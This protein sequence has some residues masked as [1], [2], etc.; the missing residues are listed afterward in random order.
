MFWEKAEQ[1]SALADEQFSQNERTPWFDVSDYQTVVGY[2]CG[3]VL[4]H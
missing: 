3:R 1:H 2:L 4:L